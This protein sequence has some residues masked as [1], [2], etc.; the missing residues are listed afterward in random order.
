MQAQAREALLSYEL[1]VCAVSTSLNIPNVFPSLQ[2]DQNLIKKKYFIDI[3]LVH[4]LG[5]SC[6][7]FNIFQ[8]LMDL[9]KLIDPRLNDSPRNE[10]EEASLAARESKEQKRVVVARFKKILFRKRH[11]YE[12]IGL[13]FY[14]TVLSCH[15]RVGL[16]LHWASLF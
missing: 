9:A 5:C 10:I 13:F 8:S 6:N 1:G 4:K 15:Q 16:V 14:C 2:S 11:H 3:R 7:Q 12:A